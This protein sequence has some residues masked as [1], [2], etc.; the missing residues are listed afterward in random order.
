MRK[1]PFL[2]EFS[3]NLL[4]N[5]TDVLIMET[6]LKNPA[7]RLYNVLSAKMK[8]SQDTAE[9]AVN[10]VEELVNGFV[11]QETKSLSTREDILL[12]KEDILASEMRLTTL[13]SDKISDQYKWL[14]G[15]LIAVI[16]I[17]I[18]IYFKK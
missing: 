17:L 15:S 4:L 3:I 13:I 8:F 9:E 7:L 11:K 12:L 14:F 1:S 5:F 2:K 16:G 6:M 18:A 10:A